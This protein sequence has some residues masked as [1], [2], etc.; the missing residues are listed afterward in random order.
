[1]GGAILQETHS[2][3]WVKSMFQ[4]PFGSIKQIHK[5]IQFYEDPFDKHVDIH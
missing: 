2:E 4:L 1:M 3:L 5:N